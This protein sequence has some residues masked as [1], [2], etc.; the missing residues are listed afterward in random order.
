MSIL[1]RMEPRPQ[2]GKSPRENKDRRRK[3]DAPKASTIRANNV[4]DDGIRRKATGVGPGLRGDSVAADR[5]T[6]VIRQEIVQT[7]A[8][9]PQL[10]GDGEYAVPVM[11]KEKPQQNEPQEG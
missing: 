6:P 11:H 10:S 7:Y 8:I 3:P 4:P 5:N 2:E 9:G 1:D